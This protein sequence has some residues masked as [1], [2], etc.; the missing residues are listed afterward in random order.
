M[1]SSAVETRSVEITIGWWVQKARVT[2]VRP[3][4]LFFFNFEACCG[5]PEFS[6]RQ[7]LLFISLRL[8][9]LQ[10]AKDPAVIT[11]QF[12]CDQGTFLFSV[13]ISLSFSLFMCC[14]KGCFHIYYY[15]SV[16]AQEYTFSPRAFLK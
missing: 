1:L 3:A 8:T 14:C 12:S 2:S 15:P 13:L 16:K 11:L 4:S 9:L 10:S 5:R 6:L 7:G